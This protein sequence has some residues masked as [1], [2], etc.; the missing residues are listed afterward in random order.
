M[1]Y[2]CAINNNDLQSFETS[3]KLLP[4]TVGRWK[5]HIPIT[6]TFNNSNRFRIPLEPI[7]SHK[8]P[9][10]T[11]TFDKSNHVLGAIF[12]RITRAWEQK[13]NFFVED[14]QQRL[15]SLSIVKD[16]S[17]KLTQTDV[18]E[19]FFNDVCSMVF[20]EK[21]RNNLLITR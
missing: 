12:P 17:A 19:T 11:R 13:W 9:P 18:I 2:L 6:R 15:N 8:I 4:T 5:P 21:K 14:I 10:I 1:R 3:G 7:L 20:S 16:I